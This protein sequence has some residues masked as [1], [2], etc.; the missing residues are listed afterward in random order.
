MSDDYTYTTMEAW[1]S[2]EGGS[3]RGVQTPAPGFNGEVR[4]RLRD[5]TLQGELVLPHDARACVIFAHGSDSSRHSPRNET[6]ARAIRSAGIGTLLFD[7]LTP[8]EDSVDAVTTH[9]RFDVGLLADRLIEA[10]EWTQKA[11]EE[12]HPRSDRGETRF[13]YFGAGTGAGAAL[14]AASRL[15]SSVQ[16]VVSRGGRADLAG[17]ALAEVRSAT[18]L[19]VGEHDP[20]I[21]QLNR[22]AHAHLVCRKDLRVIRGATHSFEESTALDQVSTLTVDW[23]RRHLQGGRLVPRTRLSGS[24]L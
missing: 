6:I 7:L 19:I 10:T 2:P 9:L 16:A 13:G 23:F 12:R 1:S 4:V 20:A 15:G 14:I 11:I 24:Q 3:M 18:L 5:V 22:W 17:I 21:L 8:E